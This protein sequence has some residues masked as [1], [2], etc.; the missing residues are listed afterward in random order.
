M[1]N[2]QIKARLLNAVADITPEI[3]DKLPLD[4]LSSHTGGNTM[5]NTKT[6][7]LPIGV[8]AF[9]ACAAALTLAASAVVYTNNFMVSSLISLDVNPSIVVEVNKQDKVLRATA[10]NE[11]AQKIL[12]NIDLKNT[13]LHTAINAIMGSMIKNGY[14]TPQKNSV[15]VT[16]KND[17][18]QKNQQLTKAVTQSIGE[19]LSQN[20]VEA[21]IFNLNGQKK[22]IINQGIA[23]KFDVSEG[24]LAFI[25]SLARLDSSLTL[26]QLS[27]MTIDELADLIRERNID[28]SHIIDLNE[29]KNLDDLDGLI[30]SK[31]KNK[32]KDKDKNKNKDKDNGKGPKDQMG[33]G[34]MPPGQVEDRQPN[35][36]TKD[37][38]NSSEAAKPQ[39]P[40]K[41]N[42]KGK[43]D[44]KPNN[45]D[46]QGNKSSKAKPD[47]KP[48]NDDTQGN[49]SSKAK[50]T[51]QDQPKPS[52]NN[53][54]ASPKPD[55]GK[56]PKNK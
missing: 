34:R 2:R 31:P 9:A 33:S 41:Q 1:N 55:Q 39:D 36:K 15:L 12:E 29:L 16:V 7:K 23:K 10:R 18:Q 30:E 8:A 48:N 46:A 20:N 52:S 17:N 27:K 28:I 51:K 40:G 43:P 53:G 35:G 50:P 6:K 25:V 14:I 5:I 13:R 21:N 42:N 37:Q 45:D 11:D 47:N 56:P 38:A 54:K 32:D 22:G 49:K 44:T 24:K 19:T 4:T 26:E 3:F